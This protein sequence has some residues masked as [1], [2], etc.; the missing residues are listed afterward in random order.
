M[1]TF[2]K[3]NK[4]LD[5][6]VYFL[7]TFYRLI[8]LSFFLILEQLS[9]NLLIKNCCLFSFCYYVSYFQLFSISFLTGLTECDYFKTDEYNY[10]HFV[11]LNNI[12][13]AQPTGYYARVPVYVIGPRDGHI[14]LS[15]TNT[16]N[17]DTD[18]VYEFCT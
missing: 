5:L 8:H 14:I 18:V 17:R 9:T 12:K 16:P 4:N 15:T 11:D 6:C 7:H 1:T 13:D 10:T 3:K 2:S